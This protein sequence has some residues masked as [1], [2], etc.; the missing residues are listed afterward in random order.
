MLARLRN[1]WIDTNRNRAAAALPEID[2]EINGTWPVRDGAAE[3][4]SR[5]ES[6]Y[7]NH[8]VEACN[9]APDTLVGLTV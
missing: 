9:R 7:D 1:A 8:K 6:A 4:I 2:F 5:F 3:F